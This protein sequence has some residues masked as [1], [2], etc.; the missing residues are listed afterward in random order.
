MHIKSKKTLIKI[1]E[2]NYKTLS[3]TTGLDYQK[4]LVNNIKNLLN[5]FKYIHL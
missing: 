5:N 2:L 1:N 3:K 4:D